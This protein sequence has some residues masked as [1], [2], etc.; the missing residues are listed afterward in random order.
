M[1]LCRINIDDLYCLV[2]PWFEIGIPQALNRRSRLSKLEQLDLSGNCLNEKILPILGS[3]K[4]LK[5]LEIGFNR[6]EGP[7]PIKAIETLTSL[8]AIG[9]SW[10]RFNDSQSIQ[11]LC[12]LKDL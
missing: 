4:S 2:D 8:R 9:F 7:L 3:L 6:F 5:E 10:N 11:G 12:K 1:V